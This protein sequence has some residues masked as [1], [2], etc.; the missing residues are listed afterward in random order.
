MLKP[1]LR[2]RLQ[3]TYAAPLLLEAW[4]PACS[5]LKRLSTAYIVCWLLVF[6]CSY[7]IAISTPA[8]VLAH[9]TPRLACCHHLVIP[10][11]EAFWKWRRL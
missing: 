5:L 6:F 8:A 1:W 11:V 4:P 2:A 3:I 9:T 10:S 7:S